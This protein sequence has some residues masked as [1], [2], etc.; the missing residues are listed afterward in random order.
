M[1]RDLILRHDAMNKLDILI[2]AR[3]HRAE[4]MSELVEG[5]AKF[6]VK[7]ARRIKLWLDEEKSRRLLAEELYGMDERQLAD[8][9]LTRHDISAILEGRFVDERP[10][11]VKAEN[12]PL[13]P[14]ER[15]HP[16]AA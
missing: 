12:K 3:M 8:I 4:M 11:P 14:G 2:E 1:I 16:L 7:Q 9:G 13:P 5:M 15:Y 10:H 6:F